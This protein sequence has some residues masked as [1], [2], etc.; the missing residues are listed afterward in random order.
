MCYSGEQKFTG[1]KIYQHLRGKKTRRNG[2]FF[3]RLNNIYQNIKFTLTTI[4]EQLF[5][6]IRQDNIEQ[7]NEILQEL[8]ILISK[9]SEIDTEQSPICNKRIDEALLRDNWNEAIQI[10]E[11]WVTVTEN[12]P[13]LCHGTRLIDILLYRKYNDAI[14]KLLT[15]GNLTTLNALGKLGFNMFHRFSCNSRKMTAWEIFIENNSQIEVLQKLHQFIYLLK[16][17]QQG[18]GEITT[19]DSLFHIVHRSYHKGYSFRV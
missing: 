12:L 10:L 15:E 11:E 13:C 2:N 18:R 16:V 17:W 6:A 4:E 7:V 1:D 19:K 9:R 5:D 8:F 3:K 14:V